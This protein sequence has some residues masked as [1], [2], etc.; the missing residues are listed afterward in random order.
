MVEKGAGKESVFE[1]FS[2][3]KGKQNKQNIDHICISLVHF[4]EE[5]HK[6]PKAPG[7]DAEEFSAVFILIIPDMTV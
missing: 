6:R 1:I 5:I 3:N 4:G 2:R 7:G